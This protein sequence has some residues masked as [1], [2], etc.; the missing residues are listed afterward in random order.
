M[1]RRRQGGQS[2]VEFAIVCPVLVLLLAGAIDFGLL[3]SQ[4]LEIANAARVGVRWASKH[5]TAWTNAANPADTTIQGEIIYAGDTREIPNDDTHIQIKYYTV[6]GSTT[7]YCG[8][9]TESS[10]SFTAAT[11]YTQS[12][13]VIAGSLVVVT[14]NYDYPA[15]TPYFA[16]IF[17]TTVRVSASAAMIEE[18]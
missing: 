18:V 16:A 8:T 6:S 13:C 4:R 1:R 10:N 12:T 17:G 14:I 3:Y 7:T 5:P 15:L 2:L 11:G 9:Y